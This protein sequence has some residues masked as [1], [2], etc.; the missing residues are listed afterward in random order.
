MRPL[1]SL[2]IVEKAGGMGSQYLIYDFS[3][4]LPFNALDIKEESVSLPK[5]LVSLLISIGVFEKGK[6]SPLI[7]AT[8][9]VH[10]E[11][12]SGLPK[13]PLFLFILE[14]EGNVE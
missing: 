10:T 2:G 11:I 4:P 14:M 6:L 5:W 3:C 1:S 9:R 13:C 7:M 8:Q 12:L